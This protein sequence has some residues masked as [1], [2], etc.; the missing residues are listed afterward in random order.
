MSGPHLNQ[1][2]NV[3]ASLYCGMVKEGKTGGPLCLALILRVGVGH[4]GLT[5][6]SACILISTIKWIN[7]DITDL[8]DVTAEFVGLTIVPAEQS[9]SKIHFLDFV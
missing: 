3:Y 7:C 9:G 2:K 5:G 1:N 6:Q 4:S 8:W